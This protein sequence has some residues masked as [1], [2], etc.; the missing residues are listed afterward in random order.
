[1]AEQ[2]LILYINASS[3]ADT[4][5]GALRSLG[6]DVVETT[7]VPERETLANY[8]A[9]ILRAGATARLTTIATRLRSAPMFGRRVLIALVPSSVDERA[10]RDAIHSGF[11]TVVP[12]QCSARDLTA[13]ILTLLRKYPEH[14]CVLR[15][16][17]GRRRAA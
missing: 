10:R 3:F 4:H 17:N 13:T 1:V 15:S 5:A 11:D 16:L 9:V 7:D 6:F 8:H 12:Q 2:C 14:R